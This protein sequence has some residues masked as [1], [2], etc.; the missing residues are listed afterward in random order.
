MASFFTA[1]EK[2]YLSSFI[3]DI[4]DTWKREIVVYQEAE[5]TILSTDP[6]FN[7]I[8]RRNITNV[9]VEVSKSTIEARIYY[10]RNQEV[11]GIN[12]NG[13]D[14][15]TKLGVPIGW[16]RL[17]VDPDGYEVLKDAKRIEFDGK[18]FKPLSSNRP[19]GLFDVRY[20]TFYLQP[21][22]GEI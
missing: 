17:K 7:P 5:K 22:E 20:Y 18:V 21:I 15:Q 13:L 12:E 19:H 3:D 8:F 6:N 10:G 16:V 1:A 11:A 14:F 9:E 4:H 2:D